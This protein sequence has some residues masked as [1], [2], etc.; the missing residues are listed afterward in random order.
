MKKALTPIEVAQTTGYTV[1]TLAVLRCIGGGP[2][3]FKL[4]RSVRYWDEDV[5]GWMESCPVQRN[6]SDTVMALSQ[7]PRSLRNIRQSQKP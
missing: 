1:G 7:E 4:G 2:H 5:L 3:F 6:T